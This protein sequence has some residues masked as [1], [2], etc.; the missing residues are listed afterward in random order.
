MGNLY[1]VFG[2]E[3]CFA[4]CM[5]ANV[6]FYDREDAGGR[7]AERLMQFKSESLIVL[8]LPRG[9]IVLGAEVSGKL[10]CPLDLIIPRKIGHPGNPEYAIAA[11]TESGALVANESEIASVDTEWFEREKAVQIAE[12]K[13]RR[14]VYLK[15]RKQVNLRGKTI[16]I[17]DDGIATGLTMKAAISEVKAKNPVKIIVA[18]PVAPADIYKQIKDEVDDFVVVDAPEYYLGSVGAYYK[19]FPQVTDEEVIEIIQNLESSI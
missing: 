14:K 16:I 12:A 18:V 1:I 17:I 5:N 6:Y 3:F 4:F 8:A 9:G 19:N 13:R 10:N 11:V 15:G 7:L 2:R